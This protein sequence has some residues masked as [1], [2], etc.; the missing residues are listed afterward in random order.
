L[1]GDEKIWSWQNDKLIGA[2]LFPQGPPKNHYLRSP[3]TYKDF[4]LKFQAKVESTF[5]V[6]GIQVR[7]RAGVPIGPAKHLGKFYTTYGIAKHLKT[8][9][10]QDE[11]EK[12]LKLG[13]NDFHLKCVGK[14]VTLTINGVTTIDEDF[15][16]LLDEGPIAFHVFSAAALILSQGTFH[17]IQIRDLTPA[18]PM[19]V[20]K[21]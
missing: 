20:N 1:G 15:A 19:K 5:G 11:L 10:N 3:K 18:K 21:P 17:D 8:G 2:A 7:G 13:F 12:V 4:E 6:G 9:T 16:D 14:H